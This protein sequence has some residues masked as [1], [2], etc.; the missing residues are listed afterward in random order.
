MTMKPEYE[1][2]KKKILKIYNLA[3]RGVGGEALNAKKLLEQW[4]RKYDL[5]LSDILAEQ[6]EKQL[7]EIKGAGQKHYRKLLFNCY[8]K[9]M[10]VGEVSYKTMRGS[11]RIWFELTA[12]QYAELTAMF[13]WHKAQ[14]D[15]ELERLKDDATTAFIHKHRLFPDTETG[16]DQTP[17]TSEEIRRLMRVLEMADNMENVTYT[18]MLGTGK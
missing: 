12:Y 2:I 15:K 7:Y 8:A 13:E 11:K 17:L 10:N 18:K 14:L 9:V 5:C 16:A 4:L 3:E 6:N 1:S